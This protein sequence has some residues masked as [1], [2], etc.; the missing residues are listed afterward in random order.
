MTDNG[1]NNLKVYGGTLLGRFESV[2]RSHGRDGV[3]QVFKE[4]I[5][6]GYDGPSHTGEIEQ[7]E[8]YPFNYMM[9]FLESYMSLYGESDFNTMSRRAPQMK[10]TV[11]WY[12][13]WSKKPSKLLK[14]S[15]KYWQNFYDFGR[16]EGKKVGTVQG[17]L[18]GYDVCVG[19]KLFCKSLT[20]YFEGVMETIDIQA[21]AKHT[22]CSLDGDHYSEWKIKW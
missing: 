17:V 4:M 13:K 9:N 2:K 7:K 18:K 22:R 5:K 11:G 12:V 6:S 16:L 20:K 15:K 19:S 21:K 10:E 14:K 8:K 3:D 1:Y